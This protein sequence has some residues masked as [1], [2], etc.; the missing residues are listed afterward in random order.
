MG[1]K[2]ILLNTSTSNG[3]II[4]DIWKRYLNKCLFT[5]FCIYCIPQ[6]RSPGHIK[7]PFCYTLFQMPC[8]GPHCSPERLFC[9]QEWEYFAHWWCNNCIN[10]QLMSCSFHWPIFTKTAMIWLHVH[11]SGFIK[12]TLASLVNELSKSWEEH[13][14][15]RPKRVNLSLMLSKGWQT[16]AE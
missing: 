14:Y 1:I 15:F 12:P 11:C 2:N 5:C 13:A 7:S 8:R 9:E 4:A 10:W 3:P 16:L 6:F